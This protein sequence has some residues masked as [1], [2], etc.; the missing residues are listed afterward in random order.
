LTEKMIIVDYSSFDA[1]NESLG[2]VDQLKS[3]KEQFGYHPEYAL[4]DKIHLT[5][6]NRKLMKNNGVKHTGSPLGRPR[7][8][9]KQRAAKTKKRTMKEIT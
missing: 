1:F 5:R 9:N 4:A 8:I 6:S 3:Y 7:A 2:F